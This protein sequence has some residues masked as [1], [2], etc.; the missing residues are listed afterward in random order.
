MA[1]KDYSYHSTIEK[2]PFS[3]GPQ[4]HLGLSDD[5]FYNTPEMICQ[6][7]VVQLC[8]LSLGDGNR[9]NLFQYST[10]PFMSNYSPRKV[11]PKHLEPESFNDEKTTNSKFMVP[12][13]N[14]NEIL[15]IQLVEQ[16]ATDRSFQKE[17]EEKI[18][19]AYEEKQELLR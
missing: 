11:R 4:S 15:R 13:P 19:K 12:D 7:K 17:R 8:P 14:E 3:K 6:E 2:E 1:R 9:N 10:N 16:E 18:M 5:D